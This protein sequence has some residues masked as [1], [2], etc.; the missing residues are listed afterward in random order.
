[1]QQGVILCI[2][3]LDCKIVFR[4]IVFR[5]NHIDLLHG[6]VLLYIEHINIRLLH[7]A[8]SREAKVWIREGRKTRLREELG[9]ER[10]GVGHTALIGISFIFVVPYFSPP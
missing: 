2:N 6:K 10:G 5:I 8:Q 3:I 4:K 1:M 9:K 7:W